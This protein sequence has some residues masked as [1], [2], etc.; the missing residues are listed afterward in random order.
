MKAP[1]EKWGKMGENGEK[2]GKMGRK[3]GGNGGKGDRLHHPSFLSFPHFPP[4]FPIS[5]PFSPIFPHFSP[6]FLAMGTLWVRLWV[7]YPPPEPGTSEPCDT[8]WSCIAF[9]TSV[10]ESTL[11]IF[12]RKRKK[13]CEACQHRHGR[14]NTTLAAA[15]RA[16]LLTTVPLSRT[17]TCYLTVHG[18]KHRG[19]LVSPLKP[20]TSVHTWHTY[21]GSMAALLVVAPEGWRGRH[22][23][24]VLF[25]GTRKLSREQRGQKLNLLPSTQT[26]VLKMLHNP[27]ERGLTWGW[28]GQEVGNRRCIPPICR[29]RAVKQNGCTWPLGG[30]AGAGDD[31]KGTT[32]HRVNSFKQIFPTKQS[33][34]RPIPQDKLQPRGCKC[35]R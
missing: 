2:W 7:Q 5:P 17:D 1:E 15:A 27:P 19:Q 35:S 32:A 22:L 20:R 6:F 28:E 18:G 16:G 30:L 26:P 14:D 8:F 12:T 10:V 21:G 25:L 3:C 23:A 13:S 11:Q 29:G 9:P 34:A 33:A 31:F 24:T 4:F